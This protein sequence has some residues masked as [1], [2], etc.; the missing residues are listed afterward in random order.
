MY[1]YI[2]WF[3][4]PYYVIPA[5]VNTRGM[6]LISYCVQHIFSDYIHLFCWGLPYTRRCIYS[7]HASEDLMSTLIQSARTAWGNLIRRND[8]SKVV[9]FQ[10]LPCIKCRLWNCCAHMTCPN[11]EKN[12]LRCSSTT[13]HGSNFD[14]MYVCVYIYVNIN[15]N[16]NIYKIET[17]QTQKIGLEPP[18]CEFWSWNHFLMGKHGRYRR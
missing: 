1:I 7:R 5:V 12:E 9:R 11:A 14:N 18:M 8:V 6:G 15:I 16:I 2:Y 3:W 10:A 4:G 17:S 13:G